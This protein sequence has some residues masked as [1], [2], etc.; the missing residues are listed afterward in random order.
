MSTPVLNGQRGGHDAGLMTGIFNAE[1]PAG[2]N[3][4]H[5]YLL[6]W[7]RRQLDRGGFDHDNRSRIH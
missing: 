2:V 4:Y 6:P 7:G 5:A 1:F 3:T